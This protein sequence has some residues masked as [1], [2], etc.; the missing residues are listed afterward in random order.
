MLKKL[1]ALFFLVTTAC[2]T[3]QAETAPAPSVVKE[4]GAPGE[5]HVRVDL[6]SGQRYEIYGAAVIGDSIMGQSA[7]R[8]GPYN[9]RVVVA[10]SDV[11]SV[12]RLKFSGQTTAVALAGLALV[13]AALLAKIASGPMM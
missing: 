13:I 9:K 8:A 12:E 4:A 5:A 10:T 1:T 6:T 2:T 7:P 11:K 3:W